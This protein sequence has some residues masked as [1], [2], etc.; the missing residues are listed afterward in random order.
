LRQGSNTAADFLALMKHLVATGVLLPGDVL[1]LDNASIHYALEIR[2]ELDDLLA[3]AQVRLLFM[4]TYS[5]ELNPCELCFGSS[6]NYMYRRR[7]S[8]EFEDEVVN[9]LA[10][11]TPSDM[12]GFYTKCI[13][14]IFDV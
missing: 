10:H 14:S 3:N 6:K 4:P 7:G 11:I 12:L 5:P 2:D 8:F 9:S 13:E 1:V